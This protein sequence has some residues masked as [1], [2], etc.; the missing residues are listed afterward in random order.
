MRQRGDEGV[1]L[2]RSFRPLARSISFISRSVQTFRDAVGS[3]SS[4]PHDEFE[5]FMI[6]FPATR[7]WG[8]LYFSYGTSSASVGSKI[9]GMRNY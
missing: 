5:Y 1:I 8:L 6:T 7:T 3:F 2:C 9:G 4:L